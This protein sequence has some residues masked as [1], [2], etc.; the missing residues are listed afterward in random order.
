MRRS[1][2]LAT[3]PHTADIGG[4]EILFHPEIPA[5]E[6]L[7]AYELVREASQAARSPETVTADQLRDANRAVRTFLCGL[8]LPESA[9]VFEEMKLPSRIYA[10]LLEFVLEL[11]GGGASGERPTGSSSGSVPRSPRAGTPG[12]GASPSKASRSARGR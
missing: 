5:D 8:M 2:A 9:D 11:Y 4:T 6:F 3:E 10:E 12:R 1:F 7:D